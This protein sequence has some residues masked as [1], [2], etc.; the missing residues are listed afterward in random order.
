MQ[1]GLAGAS[2]GSPLRRE[3]NDPSPGSGKNGVV[4]HREHIVYKGA[5]AFPEYCIWYV[6]DGTCQCA[7]CVLW[8]CIASRACRQHSILSWP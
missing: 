4:D 7:R 2:A 1:G 8:P 3:K 5:Q 6:H